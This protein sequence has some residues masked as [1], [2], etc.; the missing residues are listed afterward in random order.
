[1]NIGH[2]LR[3]AREEAGLSIRS[4]AAKSGVSASTIHRIESGAMSPTIDLANKVLAVLGL[5]T[6][7][8]IKPSQ[9]LR[10]HREAVTE[11]LAQVGGKNLR[12][13]GSV[14]RETDTP[15]S[16]ID[17]LVELP[18]TFGALDM[19]RMSTELE[20]LLG[21]PVD[22]VDDWGSSE[23]LGRARAEAVPL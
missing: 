9:A 8:R 14:A 17:L 18:D 10:N 12:V 11:L 6:Q 4:L 23:I 13:F 2:E 3:N 20:A 19:A 15:N 7:V 21:Y 5:A 16:D 22:L 1:M